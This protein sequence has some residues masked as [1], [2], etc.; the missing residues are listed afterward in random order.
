[1]EVFRVDADGITVVEH[2]VREGV[3]VIQDKAS[4]VAIYVASSKAGERARLEARRSGLLSVERSIDFN[5]AQREDDLAV[6]RALL[7]TKSK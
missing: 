4:R 5:P 6:L 3:L 7:Q 2:S 1:V